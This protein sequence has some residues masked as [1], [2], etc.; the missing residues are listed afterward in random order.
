MLP[1]TSTMD[2]TQQQL[3]AVCQCQCPCECITNDK[4]I[5]GKEQMDALGSI[6]QQQPSLVNVLAT[7][8]APITDIMLD[9]AHCS[10]DCPLERIRLTPPDKVK[11][12]CLLKVASRVSELE[13]ALPTLTELYEC[14]CNALSDIE[15]SKVFEMV[16]E[17]D[18]DQFPH[19]PASMKDI[20]MSKLA[21]SKSPNNAMHIPPS[22]TFEA[23]DRSGLPLLLEAMLCCPRVLDRVSREVLGWVLE[24][25]QSDAPDSIIVRQ[26]LHA[27][28]STSE[29]TMRR[30]IFKQIDSG[31]TILDQQWLDFMTSK[32]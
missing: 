19:I 6:I 25:A 21:I 7:I 11:L 15:W 30:V 23:H 16:I 4:C 14:K 28:L 9:Q 2:A 18:P 22:T 26:V 17:T 1:E 20:H 5:I 32:I 24:Y 10:I 29:H 3:C 27:H 13:G 31:Q 12:E 8:G